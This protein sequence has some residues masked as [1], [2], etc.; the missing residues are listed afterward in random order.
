[1]FAPGKKTPLRLDR[2]NRA[3]HILQRIRDEAHRFA[4]RYNRKLRT[5]RTLRS[6][7]GDIPGIGLRR[8]T[9]LLRR[10]GSLKGVKSA[11]KE[12]IARVPGFSK[13]LAS[14]VLTYLGN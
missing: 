1:M 5:K 3:L 13:A 8:Q 4:V 7:L 12:E 10:F 9:V 6:E 2:R 11:T 14:R